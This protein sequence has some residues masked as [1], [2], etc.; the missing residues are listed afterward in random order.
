VTFEKCQS[1]EQIGFAA[2]KLTNYCGTS[3]KLRK[4]EAPMGSH[5]LTSGYKSI[6]E[7]LRARLVGEDYDLPE[8]G[9]AERNQ[10]GGYRVALITTHGPELPEFD[11]PLNYLRDRGASVDVLTQD[12][13]FDWQPEASGYIVLAQW[14]AVNVCVKADKKISDAKVQDYDA[15]I[16][17]GGAW[18]PI[19]LRT[20]EGILK[21]ICDAHTRRLL[22]ASICHGPQV[23]VSSNVFPRGTLATGVD[24]IRTDMI[25]AGFTVIDEPVV[26]D[27]GQRL[28]TSPNPKAQPLKEFCEELGARLR[29]LPPVGGR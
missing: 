10:L 18:N 25:N 9:A 20:D 15:V 23:L 3:S 2:K 7:A 5:S 26:Y 14:L 24:D 12:W 8:F 28:I 22:I 29:E 16:I 6:P 17:I 11:V 13:L 19:M 21:F 1:A 27:K 4:K